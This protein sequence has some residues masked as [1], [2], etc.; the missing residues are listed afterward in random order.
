MCTVWEGQ[1]SFPKAWFPLKKREESPYS[2]YYSSHFI[3]SQRFRTLEVSSVTQKWHGAACSPASLR[4]PVGL[5]TSWLKLSP[6][7]A[8]SV[9]Q[10]CG[11]AQHRHSAAYP[12][13][14]EAQQSPLCNSLATC[15]QCKT[16]PILQNLARKANCPPS[17]PKALECRRKSGENCRPRGGCKKWTS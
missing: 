12:E 2:N 13:R 11:L 1:N 14:P 3:V 15:L 10:I 9:G 17:Y 7:G 4:L 5:H 16:N 6:L 8:A